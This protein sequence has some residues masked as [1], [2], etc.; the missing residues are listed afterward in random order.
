MGYYGCFVLPWACCQHFLGS[1]FP[2]FISSLLIYD[3]RITW[4]LSRQKLLYRNNEHPLLLWSWGND[5]S[6]ALWTMFFLCLASKSSS[7]TY[8][9][10]WWWGVSVLLSKCYFIL[11]FCLQGSVWHGIFLFSVLFLTFPESCCLIWLTVNVILVWLPIS[12][13]L[14]DLLNLED[15]FGTIFMCKLPKSGFGKGV[16]VLLKNL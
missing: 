7:L 13:D 14:G 6:F 11:S 1:F 8:S 2:L 16:N 3:S 9:V 4:F 10:S 5:L 15:F 12:L